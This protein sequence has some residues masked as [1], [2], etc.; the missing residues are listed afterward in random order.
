MEVV[1]TKRVDSKDS[2]SGEAEGGQGVIQLCKE[3]VLTPGTVILPFVPVNSSFVS[4]HGFQ[5]V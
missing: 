1:F 2:P 5:S 4:E 3:Q